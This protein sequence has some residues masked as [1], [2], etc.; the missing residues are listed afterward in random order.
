MKDK[1]RWKSLAAW[2]LAL[3]MV[4]DNN[5][6]LVM[7]QSV[8]ETGE[9][10]QMEEGFM[11]AI[12]TGDISE[13][14]DAANSMKSVG[15]SEGFTAENE[16][17]NSEEKWFAE[18]SDEFV[19]DD[20]AELFDDGDASTSDSTEEPG[21]DG[22]NNSYTEYR[23]PSD[24]AILISHNVWVDKSFEYYMEN[25]GESETVLIPITGLEVYN[26]EDEEDETPV[27]KIE[28]EDENGWNIQPRRMGHAIVKISYNDYEGNPQEH[29]FNIWVNGDVYSLETEWPDGS[30]IM[31]TNSEM[32]VEVK[33]HHEW[34]YADG[35]DGDDY[36]Q[37]FSLEFNPDE[38]QYKYDEN[39]IK[40]DINNAGNSTSKYLNIQSYENDGET[41]IR[42]KAMLPGEENPVLEENL[43]VG[44]YGAYTVLLPVN[45]DNPSVGEYVDFS[46]LQVKR[47]DGEKTEILENVE[48]RVEDVDS[49]IWQIE[50]TTEN[51]ESEESKLPS[52][53]RIAADGT[54]ITVVAYAPN[55]ENILEE[56]GRRDYWFDGLDYSVWFENLRGED[57]YNTEVFNNENEYELPLNTE[58]LNDKNVQ[59]R[60][61]AGYRA[62]PDETFVPFDSSKNADIYF[63]SADAE[64]NKAIIN[65]EKLEK[66]YQ[67]LS[68]SVEDPDNYWIEVRAF[69]IYGAGEGEEGIEVYRTQ[70]GVH[71]RTAVYDYSLGEYENYVIVQDNT[72]LINRYRECQIEDAEHQE[73]GNYKITNVEVANAEDEEGDT[74]VCQIE[75]ADENGW[76]IRAVRSGHAVLTLTYT[77]ALE[78][79]ETHEF[80]GNIWV[81]DDR[82]Y[83]TINFP[84]DNNNMSTDSEMQVAVQLYHEWMHN[85]EDRGNE[86]VKDFMLELDPDDS[87]YTYDKNLIEA[88]PVKQEDGNWIVKVQS[89]SECGGTRIRIKGSVKDGDGNWGVAAEETIWVNVSECFD[90]ILGNVPENVQV[91]KILDFNDCELKV[92][93]YENGEETIRDDTENIEYEIE[94]DSNMWKTLE[95]EEGKL[96]V[97]QRIDANGTPLTVNAGIRNENG[98]L[99]VI[100]RRGYDFDYLDYNVW[101]ENLRGEDFTYVFEDESYSL[102]LN[103]DALQDKAAKV[104]WEV[105]YRIDKEENSELI[106]DSQDFEKFWTEDEKDNSVLNINGEALK[107]AEAALYEKLGDGMFH[108]EVN[109]YVLSQNGDIEVWRNGTGLGSRE[110]V[111]DYHYPLL[112][113]QLFPGEEYTM[114]KSFDCYVKDQ[115]NPWGY[116]KPLTIKNVSLETI[117]SEN[118]EAPVTLR[119]GENGWVFGTTCYGGAKVTV[120]FTDVDGETSNQYDFE[121]WVTDQIYYIGD[122]SSPYEHNPSEIHFFNGEE[123]KIELKVFC[124]KLNEDGTYT[125]TEIPSG[126]YTVNVGDEENPGYDT[127]LLENVK[128]EGS[129][130]IARANGEIKG[131]DSIWVNI[132][133][134]EMNENNEPEWGVDGRV[135]F[136]VTDGYYTISSQVE[137][138]WDNFAVGKLLDFNTPAPTITI[139]RLDENGKRVSEPAANVRCHLEYDTDFWN[140]TEET[141]DRPI[142]VLKRTG[143][144]T[145]WAVLVAEAP[146][147]NEEGK[148]I[149]QEVASH[150]YRFAPVKETFCEHQ[151]KESERVDATCTKEGTITY[152]CTKCEE[153]KTEVIE[154]IAHTIVTVRDSEPT[155]GTAGKQHQE[156]SMCHG[157]RK[158][159]A[160][161]PATGN[162]SW[163]VSKTVAATCT[164]AG[165]KT[166]VCKTCKET[167]TEAIAKLAHKMVTVRDSEPTCGTAGKQHQE[168][169]MCHGERKEL[170]DLPATG[171]HSWE[172]SKTV[173]AT[174]TAAGSKTYVC[175]TCKETKIE[176]IAKLAHKMVTV[177]D[178]EPTCGTAGKQHQECSMCHGQRKNLADL[179]ATGKHK[180]GAYVTVT[181]AT[182]L[183]KGKETRTCSVCGASQS[184]N[185]AKLNAFIKV[186]ET[187]FP[188]KKGQSLELPVTL[189][190]GD[191]IKSVT[192]QNTKKLTVSKYSG[193][194]KLKVNKKAATGKVKVVVKTKGGASKTLTV[195]IQKRTVTATK[196]TGIPK[197][198]KLKVKKEVTL[199]PVVNPVSCATKVTY[200]SKNTKVATVSKTGVITAK[201]AGIAKIVVTC[202]KVSVEC[203]VTVTKK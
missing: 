152:I 158:E 29:E 134:N 23:Y 31:L 168:C 183:K 190:K 192:S 9:P 139:T 60:W 180:Y 7:A 114:E 5:G 110:N 94:Y 137:E 112:G 172:I 135:Y 99:D 26:A 54:Q 83:L 14:T 12:E 141:K 164:A 22:E 165:S 61:E 200:K 167:K 171:K 47:V 11:S 51:S 3:S 155:C 37:N 36:I 18:E 202:G 91:G 123:Q 87:G 69:V 174:C 19:S 107:K 116:T 85:E 147:I 52:L 191:S 25:N 58:N 133:S 81:T 121:V 75:D 90:K 66:A 122:I 38:N 103:T 118:G 194:I 67:W 178:S 115:E 98:D 125:T 35:N 161:L 6:A 88:A 72:L 130:I 84:D 57:G 198:L 86:E 131:A 41:E 189:E 34:N 149:W 106:T 100:V 186:S 148:E 113:L 64:S 1:K 153:T 146:F 95:S 53:R 62:K 117:D 8:E 59:I 56:V 46:G 80:F 169:S 144:D 150:S 39:L 63:L 142:P 43:W 175:K 15:S 71:S 199:N 78:E 76:N 30:Q 179:P 145:T 187:S 93:H 97:L 102:K 132:S 188:M 33:L 50:E 17:V 55:D 197:T 32:T 166:Y 181:E 45:L 136:A 49:N 143:T 70:A 177:R 92:F 104:R 108:F 109:V 127:N 27:C 20:T 159:L 4:F 68:G 129:S 162:H 151:W 24:R 195:T 170:A 156:C 48:Y 160:D 138:D 193:G 111:R 163:E 42:I 119:E 185:I 120:E 157:E 44:V 176:G 128:V 105:G 16:A 2:T 201:K 184:R 65:G 77:D 126:T 13:N 89:K 173:A 82:Y 154:K 96:P 140:P 124:Q 101:F 203:K 21:E 196:I 79:N 28:Y 10:V 74:P 182:A 40:V 73:N